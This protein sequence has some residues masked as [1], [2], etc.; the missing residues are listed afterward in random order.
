M[1]MTP[2]GHQCALQMDD[3]SISKQLELDEHEVSHPS[4]A[5]LQLLESCLVSDLRGRLMPLEIKAAAQQE[6]KVA[7]SPC[8]LQPEVLCSSTGSTADSVAADRAVDCS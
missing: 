3:T 2:C 5:R 8:W 6:S 1:P 4:D 7:S